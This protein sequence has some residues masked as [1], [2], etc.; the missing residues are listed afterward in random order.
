MSEPPEPDAQPPDRARE[1]ARPGREGAALGTRRAVP[2]PRGRRAARARRRR[3]GPTRSRRPGCSRREHPDIQVLVRVNGIT[4]PWFADDVADGAR[5]R[6]RP[7]WWCRRWS[8]P[9]TS[10]SVADA[11]G[12]AGRRAP[13]G[14]W[15]ASRARRA[16]HAPRSCCARRCGGATSA[17]RTSSPTWAACAPSR[18][19]R[20]STR[21]RGWCSRR[22]S[23]ACTPVD[24]I[25]ADFRDDDRYR[26]D[27]SEARALGYRGKLCIHPGPGR[28]RARGV[29]AVG[30]RGRPGPAAA[31]RLRGG[32]GAAA[33]PPSTSRARWSTNPWPAAP[34]TILAAAD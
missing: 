31:R 28:A 19:S 5:T 10:R 13:A 15:P 4:T 16:S 25:L 7:G 3:P 23:A 11:L 21:G 17:P 30:R 24:Q 2:R 26:R 18:T 33:R 8:R 27:A 1:P 14:S 22:G 20:C 29:H 12:A 6:A 32:R 9:P 34:A